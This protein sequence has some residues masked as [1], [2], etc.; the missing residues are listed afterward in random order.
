[1]A[2]VPVFTNITGN[3]STNSSTA[4]DFYRNEDLAK[5]E[6]LI[7]GL[8]LFFA[9]FGNTFVILVLALRRK[10]M[11]RMNIL[12]VHL[13]IADL[14]VAFFNIL[15]QL[16]WDITFRFYGNDFLCRS[17]K[18]VQVVAMYAS[19]YVLVT[20][21]VD[22][23]LVICHPLTIQ[24][25]STRRVHLLVLAAWLV[26]LGFS[27]P[28]IFI[29]GY[30]EVA[31]N[32]AV[33]DCWAQFDP[34]WTLQLYITWFTGAVY[35][36]PAAMLCLLYGRICITVWRSI[37]GKEPSAR[38]RKPIYQ[39]VDTRESPPRATTFAVRDCRSEA[40]PRAHVRVLSRS[41]V[42]T[43]KLTLTVVACYLVC[44][45]PFF[46][47]QMWAAWDATAPFNSKYMTRAT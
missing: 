34:P 8:I 21:A 14:F 24:T 6:I 32:S 17:V 40:N 11:T 9:I 27:L 19:A 37:M 36:I 29:F 45:G 38:Q 33:Y 3:G 22:R 20:T 18:Y 5:L 12:I 10:K 31:P 4:G 7:Q 25:W 47:A 13:A 46:V 42:K 39:R 15:P 28:Q 43:V 41:K 23:Y 30:R 26:S 2:I 16:I 1:M 35:V 44:W